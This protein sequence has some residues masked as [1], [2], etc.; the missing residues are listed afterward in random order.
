MV[1]IIISI[2]VALT[3]AAV[4]ALAI[5]GFVALVPGDRRP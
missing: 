4:L 1:S 3:C 2:I 5:L